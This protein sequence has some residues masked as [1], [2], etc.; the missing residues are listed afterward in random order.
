MTEEG[1]VRN[2][3][4]EEAKKYLK[5]FSCSVKEMRNIFMYPGLVGRFGI[6]KRLVEIWD[7]SLVC[8]RSLPLW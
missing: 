1:W 4:Y 2:E 3:D 7:R 5:K 6:A 8:G